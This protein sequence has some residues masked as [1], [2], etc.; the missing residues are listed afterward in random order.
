MKIVQKLSI[1]LILFLFILNSCDKNDYIEENS[2]TLIESLVFDD[3]NFSNLIYDPV[4]IDISDL[5][6]NSI[7]HYL[8]SF[9][10]G[11]SNNKKSLY[12]NVKYKDSYDEIAIK[13]K[14]TDLFKLVESWINED[15]TIEGLRTKL[16]NNKN[17]I[18]SFNNGKEFYVI[19]DYSLQMREHN[20]NSEEK[21]GVF[22]RDADP[23]DCMQKI[24]VSTDRK[25]TR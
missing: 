6:T 22:S 2:D 7:K 8:S 25:S 18:F 13:V 17:E 4:E 12:S 19:L 5:D 1:F 11:I 10:D 21:N 24:L 3:E 9:N 16:K 15:T 23:S 14:N 20:T